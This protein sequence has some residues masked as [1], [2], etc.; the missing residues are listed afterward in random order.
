MDDTIVWIILI[1]GLLLALKVLQWTFIGAAVLFLYAGES[2]FVGHVIYFGLWIVV[3]PIMALV[4]M[5]VGLFT[6]KR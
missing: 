4:C 6:P 3:F 2:G 1:V 5:L